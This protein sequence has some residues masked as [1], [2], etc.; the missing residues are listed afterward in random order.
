MQPKGLSFWLLTLKW[1][2]NAHSKAWT[3]ISGEGVCV[4]GFYGIVYQDEKK[5][6]IE[7]V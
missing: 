6:E 5:I 2:L 3:T 1:I 7:G 4:K